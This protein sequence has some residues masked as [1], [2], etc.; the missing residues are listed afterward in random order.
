MGGRY[1]KGRKREGSIRKVSS[2]LGLPRET[3]QTV[4]FREAAA[5]G[6]R[7]ENRSIEEGQKH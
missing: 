6:G 7:G 4:N 3:E 1:G 5:S 2:F